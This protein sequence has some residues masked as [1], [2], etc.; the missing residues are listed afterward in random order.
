M[1]GMPTPLPHL[2]VPLRERLANAL[3]HVVDGGGIP[4]PQR[5]PA[6]PL[7][8][9]GLLNTGELLVLPGDGR[10]PVIVSATTARLLRRMFEETS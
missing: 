3:R 2:Q 1:S 8:R 7:A 6:P 10:A 9:V 4:A 5:V